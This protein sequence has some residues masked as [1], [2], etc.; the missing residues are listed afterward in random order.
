LTCSNKAKASTRLVGNT[1]IVTKQP[2]SKVKKQTVSDHEDSITSDSTSCITVASKPI[3]VD[4]NDPTKKKLVISDPRHF[5]FQTWWK[6][7]KIKRT[8]PV[9]AFS[10]QQCVVASAT[11]E[12]CMVG[13]PKGRESRRLMSKKSCTAPDLR[14][15]CPICG[16]DFSTGWLV[17]HNF[18]IF[19][20]SLQPR[21]CDLFES[22]VFLTFLCREP[23][24]KSR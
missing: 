20:F 22:C 23:F 15:Q 5:L 18:I 24:Q 9:F 14:L 17:S 8:L 3:T 6:P 16:R 19:V 12:R 7:Q 2:P 21:P 13:V 10:L 11:T 1:Q 4:T